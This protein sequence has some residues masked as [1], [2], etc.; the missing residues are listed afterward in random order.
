MRSKFLRLFFL[1]LSLLVISGN[2]YAK[3][4]EIAKGGA[5][6]LSAEGKFIDNVLESDYQKYVT[7]KTNA[8]KT[9]RER[10][11][12]KETRDYWLNDSPMAR[13]NAFNNKAKL[14]IWY[15]YDLSNA[16][17]LDSYKPPK[18][19]HPGEIV[20]RKATTLD[21]IETTTFETYVKEMQTKYSPGTAINSPKYSPALDNQVLQGKQI[22]EIPSSNQNLS[23]IQ[24][25]IDLAKKYNIE[26]RFRS[27]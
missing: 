10:L 2:L 9:P 14:E 16:K 27:E 15:P 8:G 23:N 13:G 6:L 22:L 7:R 19:G 24:Q 1:A 18:N 20:S 21:E 17:R 11:D 5:N 3:E 26:I 12:W 25:Y 4:I